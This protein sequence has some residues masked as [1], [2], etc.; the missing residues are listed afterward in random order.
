MLIATINKFKQQKKKFKNT[1]AYQG[2]I[3]IIDS[4]NI[5]ITIALMQEMD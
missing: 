4:D 1:P 2:S 3:N 5:N